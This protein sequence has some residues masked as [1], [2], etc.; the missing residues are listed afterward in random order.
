VTER[1][2]DPR[3]AWREVLDEAALR[4]LARLASLRGGEELVWLGVGGQKPAKQLEKICEAR[5]KLRPDLEGIAKR[6]LSLIVAPEIVEE[7]GLEKALKQLRASLE[8]DGVVALVL[9]AAVG[10]AVSEDLRAAWEQ[11]QHGPLDSPMQAL[12]RFSALGFEPLT[13]EFLGRSGENDGP[14]EDAGKGEAAT[15][16]ASAPASDGKPAAAPQG[17]RMGLFIGRRVEA[18]SPPRWPRRAGME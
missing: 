12:G 6:S 17:V 9:R 13:A 18:G 16:S 3:P 4:R 1:V 11:R 8:T 2:T 10:D 15:A 7:V 14:S 5:V